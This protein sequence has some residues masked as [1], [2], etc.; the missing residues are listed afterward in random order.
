M[1][2]ILIVE[3]DSDQ[4][5]LTCEALEEAMPGVETVIAVTGHEALEKELD[6]FDAIVLDYNLPDMTGLDALQEISERKHG[7]V[8]MLTSE[9]GLEIAVESIKE[10]AVDF[11]TKSIDSHRIIPS[12]VERAIQVSI[13]RK[14]MEE[15][16]IAGR[17]KKVQI[18][19]LKRTMMTLAHH[20]NNAVMPIIFSSELCQRGA[21]APDLSARLVETCLRETGRINRVIEKF[22]RFIEEEEFTYADYLDLKDAMFDVQ[23]DNEKSAGSLTDE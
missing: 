12:V 14:K 18:E 13:Q 9:E 8:V 16:R 7:P 5:L 10:G 1:K 23:S 17:T 11:I 20:L 3:D 21:Y 2:R 6:Q 19:T 22:E 15:T 4:A